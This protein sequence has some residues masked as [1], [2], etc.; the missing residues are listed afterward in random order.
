MVDKSNL[1]A[2]GRQTRRKSS[3]RQPL[4][5]KK[6]LLYSLVI[7]LIVV[8]GAEIMV[9][10]C[11]PEY[12]HVR[13]SG[14]VTGGYPIG[15]RGEGQHLV[16][17]PKEPGEIRLAMLGDSVMWGYLLSL[18][19]TIPSQVQA[20]LG[21]ARGDIHWR[22][23]N[24]ANR[25]NAP[26]MR[27]DFFVEKL[28]TWP[29]DGVVYQ[30]HLNDLGGSVG[31]LR[32]LVRNTTPGF[33]GL[34]EHR[35]RALRESYFRMSAIY[36]FLENKLRMLR[37]RLATRRPGDASFDSEEI[38]HRWDAQFQALADMNAVCD[39]RGIAF[40]VYLFPLSH[41][42]SD[43]PRDNI[44]NFDL[45]NC[46]VDPYKRFDEYLDKYNLNG[47]HLFDVV[48]ADRDAMLAGKKPY[49]RLYS[50]FDHNHPNKRG[51]ELFADAIVE[52][53][54]DGELVTVPSPSTLRRN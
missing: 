1:L 27:R 40:R 13:N 22:S 42:L 53:I 45:N 32:S 5:R 3:R 21:A 10:K 14:T 52:D 23:I 15:N 6:K 48:K 49:N 50:V 37:Y 47:R 33:R 4:S 36:A 39:R 46:T 28:D 18:D 2:V 16:V 29:V 9:R 19:D 24:L 17:A 41:H 8:G 34:F 35:C 25:G 26:T 44:K 54:L 51:A 11:A 38:R 7:Q 30:F 31:Q 20:R 12:T 43:D